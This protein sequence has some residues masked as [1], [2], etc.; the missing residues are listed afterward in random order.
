MAAADAEHPNANRWAKF[1]LDIYGTLDLPILGTVANAEIEELARQK[2]KDNMG[3]F[4]YVFGSAGTNST[5]KANREAFDR[6]RII[7][8]ML[9]DATYRNTEVTLFGVK[10]PAPLA[11]APIGVQG[12]IHADAELA[13]ARAAAAVGVPMTMSTASTRSLEDVATA[14]GNGHR[15]YQL[16]WP[17]NDDVTISL[18]TR[19][20]EL[21]YTALLITLDTMSLGWRPHDLHSA[22]LPF[23]HGV[24]I[25]VGA[26][27]PVFMGNLGQQPTH[28]H[29]PFPYNPNELDKR[30]K[31]GDEAVIKR[32]R[33]GGEWLKETASGF[34]KNWEQLSLIK[35]H[36][37][38]P[39]VLKGIQSVE[40][41]EKAIDYVDG[42]VVSNHG[43]R[44]VDGGIA[45]LD[46]L[47]K[48]CQSP[49]VLAAQKSG[50]FT[51]LFDSGI[52][53]GSDIIKALALGAQAVLLG[54]PFM[55][56]LCLA[57]QQGVEVQV[58]TIL[59]DLDITMGLVGCKNI[60]EIHGNRALLD[61]PQ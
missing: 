6:Y 36:W 54:R 13:T 24:G 59:A 18:L 34:Y 7:P 30:I 61:I 10:Y 11:L 28:E 52:R 45:S 42:I 60:A 5:Y 26:S 19:A 44:Q 38:G 47:N 48:I 22:Y 53:T 43:G 14:N 2:M 25:A 46:A 41:A 58:K 27:D 50:K 9:I 12:I 33:L 29:S 4:M 39:I 23:R 31:A 37:D 21:N 32:A 57:G 55:Y 56:G 35:K 3:A 20:K 8:R 16:Y 17:R 15:W 51:V 1:M 40:D 49:K